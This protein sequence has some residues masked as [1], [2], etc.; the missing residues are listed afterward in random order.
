MAGDWHV[1]VAVELRRELGAAALAHPRRHLPRGE[2][3]GDDGEE[4]EGGVLADVVVGRGLTALHRPRLHRVEHLQPG[5]DLAGGEGADLEA[6]L[7]ELRDAARH[8]LGR[9]EQDVEAAREGAG[10]A[11]ADLGIRGLGEGGGGKRSGG[12]GRD[13][14]G[15][16]DLASVHR[17]LLLAGPE[18]GTNAGP[19]GR[20]RTARMT[21]VT[22]W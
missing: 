13:R 7:G 1:V 15:A 19:A 12:G 8:V 11:P 16:E 10:Q 5:H 3:E 17:G 20:R 21:G 6:V 14:G 9:A 22:A 4:G 2:A 18:G